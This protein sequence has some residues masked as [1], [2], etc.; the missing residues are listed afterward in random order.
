MQ[1]EQT[2]AESKVCASIITSLTMYE[3]F[4][5]IVRMKTGPITNPVMI[6]VKKHA[7]TKSNLAFEY[8]YMDNSGDFDLAACVL[9]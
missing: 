4:R 5:H 8:K 9:V 7:T 6:A 3:G 1:A 2:I